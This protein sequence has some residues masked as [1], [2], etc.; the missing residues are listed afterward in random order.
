MSGALDDASGAADEALAQLDEL[1][2]AL[3]AQ[4]DE[5]RRPRGGLDVALEEGSLVEKIAAVS[6]AAPAVDV[7]SDVIARQA[8]RRS[9]A[10]RGRAK[11]EFARMRDRVQAAVLG[12]SLERIGDICNRLVGAA[13]RVQLDA[14]ATGSP[15]PDTSTPCTIYSNPEELQ[16][17]ID[18]E[19]AAQEAEE[20]STTTVESAEEVAEQPDDGETDGGIEPGAYTILD[21]GALAEFDLTVIGDELVIS[22]TGDGLTAEGTFV[23][24][25]GIS[26]VNE[27]LVCTSTEVYSIGGAVA[28]TEVV[29]VPMDATSNLSATLEGSDCSDSGELQAENIAEF[30]SAAA[31]SIELDGSGGIGLFSVV[32]PGTAFA[33]LEPIG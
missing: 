5:E 29:S 27:D 26:Y 16:A 3:G 32:E 21:S 18:A 12:Q 10:Q 8:E 7:I 6:G 25:Y 14:A 9:E 11:V 22:V 1:S 28:G 2:S 19:R 15:V 33:F 30:L 4:L 13:R 17:L 24:Q 31:I 23:W 20:N